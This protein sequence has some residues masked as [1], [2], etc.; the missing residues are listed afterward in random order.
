MIDAELQVTVLAIA[1]EVQTEKGRFEA[2]SA[3][4]T[5]ILEFAEHGT[6]PDR[7]ELVACEVQT[8]RM[9]SHGATNSVSS[10]ETDEMVKQEPITPKSPCA[11]V[12]EEKGASAFDRPKDKDEAAMVGKPPKDIFFYFVLSNQK[13]AG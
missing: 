8:D 9:T 3:S 10:N 4:Q 6:Q 2:D 5:T 13:C 1:E 11:V 7:R 12:D